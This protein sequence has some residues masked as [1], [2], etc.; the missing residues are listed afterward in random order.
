LRDALADE[1]AK[2]EHRFP[3]GEIFA[4]IVARMTG[5]GEQRDIPTLAGRDL[6][7]ADCLADIPLTVTA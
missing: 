5:V 4:K 1:I 2:S 6:S 3:N 7:P